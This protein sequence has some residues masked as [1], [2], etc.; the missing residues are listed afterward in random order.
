M[1]VNVVM[2]PDTLSGLLSAAIAFEGRTSSDLLKLQAPF[3]QK[4]VTVFK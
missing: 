3:L 1:N 2:L 4:S